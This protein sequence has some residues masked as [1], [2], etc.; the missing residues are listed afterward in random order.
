MLEVQPLTT[1]ELASSLGSIAATKITVYNV[2][3]PPYNDKVKQG[4]VTMFSWVNRH[5]STMTQGNKAYCRGKFI[6][7]NRLHHAD[8]SLP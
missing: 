7:Y 8:L 4:A 5:F 2:Y 3:S 6:R 1:V